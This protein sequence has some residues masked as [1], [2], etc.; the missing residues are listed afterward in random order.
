MVTSRQLKEKVRDYRRSIKHSWN[1]FRESRIGMMGLLIMV[2]FIVVALTSP[3]MGLRDPL[4]WWAPDEDILIIDGYFYGDT[5]VETPGPFLQGMNFRMR[6]GSGTTTQCDRLYAAGG[7]GDDFTPYALYAYRIDDGYEGKEAW[8][9]PFKTD[10]RISSKVLVNNFGS[11]SNAAEADLRILF[12]CDN[13]KFYILKD[14]FID[15]SSSTAPAGANIWSAT[16]DSPIVGVCYYDQR[17]V[18]QS[19]LN[20]N[21]GDETEVRNWFAENPFNSY[22]LI[23][24]STANGTLYGFAGPAR[25]LNPV[26]DTYNV[27]KPSMIWAESITNTT[28]LTYP[29]VSENGQYVFVGTNDGMLYGLDSVTG[30]LIPDWM[31]TPYSVTDGYMSTSPITVGNPPLVY[32]STNNGLIHCIWGSN[33]TVKDGWTHEVGGS[34]EDGFEIQR[35]RVADG[36]NLTDVSMLPDG[37]YIMVGSDTGFMYTIN[38]KTAN[39]SIAFDT[40]ISTQA[41]AVRVAPYFDWRFSGYLFVTSTNMN[42]TATDP[43]DDFSILFCM[44]SAG[45]DTVIWRKSFDGV[46][47]SPV[48]CFINNDHVGSK[49]DVIITTLNYADNGN[50]TGG[51]MYS[52]S[53]SGRVITPLPPTWVTDDHVEGEERTKYDTPESGNYYW[54]GTDAQGHDILSQTL[55]GSRIALL[56]GFLSAF[57][58]IVIGVIF[59]LVSGYYGKGID[60]VL[61]RF[62]DVILVLPSLPLLITFAAIMN[63]SIWNIILIISLVG[64]GGVAR[65]IRA[66]VLSLKERPFIDSARVT[67]ASKSRIMF[68]HIAPNVLPLGLLY[69]TFAVSGAILFEAS[70]SFIGLGDP[71]SMTWGMMLNYVQHS[72]ALTNWWWLLPP[73]ICITLVC[74]AFFLL[75]RAFDEIVNP[76][77]RRRR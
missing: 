25:D 47:P 61:M 4:D 48:I 14:G 59:G 63:P 71:S 34:L 43:S 70:L 35:N 18:N 21:P 17:G 65:V 24:V 76:R 42:D 67:G 37:S 60:A 8:S 12:G 9:F 28:S 69:M 36:G 73:G 54:L 5:G 10:S 22:D 57:F 2:V 77:L 16:L 3:Y 30:D 52:Y 6:P 32:T 7:V 23:F 44:A 41:T 62:T 68:K 29:T 45:N 55:L 49:A 56:V 74:M 31:G 27:T 50:A 39:V 72:N 1:L 46:I 26:T 20:A 75:G 66:E 15:A 11:E 19:E 38:A 51:T 64:W 58:S 40:K 33:K 53:S 13:G